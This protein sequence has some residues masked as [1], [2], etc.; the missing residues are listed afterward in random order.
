MAGLTGDPTDNYRHDSP[1][2]LVATSATTDRGFE[3]G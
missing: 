1:N 3:I 2:K